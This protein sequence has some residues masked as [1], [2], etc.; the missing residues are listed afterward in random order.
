MNR[1]NFWDIFRSLLTQNSL[2]IKAS[3]WSL[4]LSAWDLLPLPAA[5]N[6]IV[7]GLITVDGGDLRNIIQLLKVLNLRF[8]AENRLVVKASVRSLKLSSRNLL[9]TPASRHSVVEG[10]VTV[11]RSNLGNVFDALCSHEKHS[12]C[13]NLFHF[14]FI[15]QIL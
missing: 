14:F 7:E 2:V 9:T 5:W 10:L 4:K 3:I 11:N 13:T 12:N 8:L 6:C 1:C 15:K